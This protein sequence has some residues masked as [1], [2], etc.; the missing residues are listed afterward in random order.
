MKINKKTIILFLVIVV[1]VSPLIISE[2]LGYFSEDK[3]KAYGYLEA[4]TIDINVNEE[5]P[6]I[7]SIVLNMID[8]EI[9]STNTVFN[10]G[11][12]PVRLY[13]EIEIIDTEEY[14]EFVSNSSEV[15]F[16][17][18]SSVWLF[19]S[20]ETKIPINAVFFVYNEE[21][22]S[23][24]RVNR[25]IRGTDLVEVPGQFDGFIYK[26]D[27]YEDDS[28]TKVI[29]VY[30]NEELVINSNRCA[31]TVNK[32]I[33][34]S[35]LPQIIKYSLIYKEYNPNGVLVQEKM[36]YD[37][38]SLDKVNQKLTY[39]GQLKPHNSFEVTQKYE[40]KNKI[41]KGEVIFNV[42]YFATQINRET[43]EKD[44]RDDEISKNKLIIN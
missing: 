4:G 37:E 35:Y 5:N 25:D 19:I 39:L 44:F 33:K 23:I 6:W 27:E 24:F 16:K 22:D 21:T 18:C 12:N 3:E 13:E 30:Y 8:K 28:K 2:G 42:N 34:A 38:V 11:T 20:N 43:L 9:S 7:S 41:I 31:E 32:S 36:V 40:I 1:L 10:E 29:A 14:L 17:G 26:F 15:E